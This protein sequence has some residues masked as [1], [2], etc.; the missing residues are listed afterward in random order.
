MNQDVQDLLDPAD[1]MDGFLRVSGTVVVD[2][3]I[4]DMW[5]VGRL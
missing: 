1:C 5:F 4:K 2:A 3:G